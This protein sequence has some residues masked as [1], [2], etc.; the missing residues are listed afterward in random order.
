MTTV[1][2]TTSVPGARL[3]YCLAVLLA[4]VSGIFCIFF[5]AVLVINYHGFLSPEG[6]MTIACTEQLP[7]SEPSY[8][9]PADDS[10]NRLPTN[11]QPFLALRQALSQNRQDETLKNQIRQLDVELRTNYFQCRAIMHYATLFL[12]ASSILFVAAVRTISVLKRQIPDP[13]E[14]RQKKEKKSPLGFAIVISWL[15]LCAGFFLGLL[16]VPPLQMEQMFLDKLVAEAN[17][18]PPAVNSETRTESAAMPAESIKITEKILIQ[19]WVSF[20]N[21]DGNGVGFS[22]N[23]PIRWNGKTGENIVWQVEV[24]MSGNSSPVIWENKLFL[25]GADEETQKIFCFNIE[26]G[27]LLWEAD[28]TRAEAKAG[29]VSEDT[30][31]AAP[32]PVVDGRHVYAMFANGELVAVDFTGKLVWRKSFGIPNNH[33]GFASSP[34]LS[35]DRLIVQFDDGDGSE[36]NSKLIAL[37]W[38]TGNILWETPR[39]DVHSTW[40]SPMIKKIGDSYQIITCA[41]PF[42]IAYNPEDGK[43]I[44]RCKCLNGGDVGPSP[45]SLG[46]VV[47]IANESPRIS[48]IDATGS[49]DVTATHILWIGANAPPDTPSPL[50]TDKYFLT[51][52]SG[53]YMTGYDPNV[54]NPKNKKAGYWELEVGDSSNFY[55]SP[56]RVGTYI[57]AFDKTKDNPRAFVIDLSKVAV[58]DDGM[59]TDE[60]AAVMIL[61][62]NP[63]PE[64][65]VTSPA[66]LNDRLYIRGVS[67]LYCIGNP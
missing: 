17:A 37:D 32:T 47:L 67:T 39:S 54:I 38:N 60:S 28:V 45:V 55:S 34:A 20:R 52:S 13:H 26:N 12:F 44:W 48:A 5:C 11:Y 16:L 57:Y 2:E 42:V 27:K 14:A 58:A 51:I 6:A 8:R 46:N 24:P 62:E 33:Y 3:L 7:S 25:T 43:E 64:P 56:L 10:F 36:G 53:G 59:L 1:L 4:A 41:N 22:D 61:A 63:M 9:K 50:A 35:F 15:M 65:C 23:P 21:F 31:Y 19:N 66:V 30:G 49:G 29:E 18:V 40:A